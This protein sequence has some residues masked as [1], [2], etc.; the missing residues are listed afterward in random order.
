MVVMVRML[1]ALSL[2]QLRQFLL[3]HSGRKRIEAILQ[4][5]FLT[6]FAEDKLGEFSHQ[7][8]KRFAWS[9]VNI[10]H[11]KTAQGVSPIGHILV[12]RL[13]EWLSLFCC[14]RNRTHA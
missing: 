13:V 10:N 11:E 4:H 8:V 2:L 7:W 9:P 12:I 5:D 1:T 3:D 14:Q 6:L